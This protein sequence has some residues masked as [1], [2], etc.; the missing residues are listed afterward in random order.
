MITN[1]TGLAS[2]M[3]FAID[4][5]KAYVPMYE[6]SGSKPQGI[7]TTSDGGTT[8]T[9]QTTASFSNSA[10]FPNCVHFFNATD[11]WCMGDPID[12]EFEIY[13]TTN[14][15]TN[16]TAV[17]GSAIPNPTSGE[18]GVV[19]YYSVVNDTIWFGTNMGRV[20]RSPD[21]GYTWTVAT[22]TPFS[23]KYIKPTFRNGSHGL[24]Q[25]KGAGTTGAIC[26]SFDGGLTWTPVTT[27]GTIY[28]TDLAYVPGSE[29]TWVSS[30]AT[31]TNGSSYSFDGG[32]TWTDFV[33]TSGAQYMQMTWLNNHC[34]WAGGINA[35]PTENGAYKYIGNLM[36]PLPP[37]VNLQ[38]DVIGHDVHLSW[39]P[40]QTRNLVGYNMYRNDL[41]INSAPITAMTYIDTN[42][43]SGQYTYC[44]TAIYTQ[45][46]S[47]TVCTLVDVAVGIP[48]ATAGTLQVYPNPAK[49]TLVIKLS[50]GSI[51]QGTEASL[52]DISGREVLGN[53]VIINGNL[54]ISGLQN[55]YYLLKIH[56][57]GQE[58]LAKFLVAK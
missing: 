30:G 13:T 33:G 39:E 31:G 6:V 54:D 12:G 21:K 36:P 46:E 45:G 29:N 28:A 7:Y 43:P 19:G 52:F 41:K 35:S 44:V 27:T 47:A 53:A 37:P 5:L 38:A 18:F 26:E 51:P 14:G 15:G 56:S 17:A 10:S 55:G 2:A 40:P 4:S 16:W 32:H 42:V 34:G 3:I 8:W 58:Y 48:G 57:G 23:G 11:G 9:R 49:E 1:T 25:D 20:Y 50:G 24:V 22:V